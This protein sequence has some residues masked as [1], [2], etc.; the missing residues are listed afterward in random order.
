MR[1]AAGECTE[2]IGKIVIQHVGFRHIPID[3]QFQVV[4]N[5][6]ARGVDSVFIADL[7]HEV[8]RAVHIAAIHERRAVQVAIDAGTCLTAA[9]FGFTVE[10]QTFGAS[11]G[12]DGLVV[13][14]PPGWE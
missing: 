5:A 7:R 10:H 9:L 4:T 1:L 8:R 13:V 14:C 11:V 6:R 3:N 12:F 2:I